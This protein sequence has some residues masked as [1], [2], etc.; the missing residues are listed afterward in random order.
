MSIERAHSTVVAEVLVDR[1]GRIRLW[2]QECERMFGYQR[3]HV[4]G[5]PVDFLILPR[6]R[7]RHW[8]G[9]RAAM[10]RTWAEPPHAVGNIPVLHANG[11]V[12]AHPFRQII[13]TDAF[14]QATGAIVIFSIAMSPGSSNG[15][16][17]VFMDAAD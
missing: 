4:L 17:N 3:Q 13:L 10:A 6:L 15:L 5:R 11:S 1:T 8:A 12:Q 9:F 14:G 16:R 2:D 7:A